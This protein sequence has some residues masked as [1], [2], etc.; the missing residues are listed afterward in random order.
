MGKPR[1]KINVTLVY[2]VIWT[3]I[4]EQGH[5]K[6]FLRS[7]RQLLR[8]NWATNFQIKYSYIANYPF[9]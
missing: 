8:I 9:S 7:L 3:L 6:R 5:T 4:Q 1:L 2:K